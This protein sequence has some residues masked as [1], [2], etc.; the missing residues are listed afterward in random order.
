MVILDEHE[1]RPTVG[2][3]EDRIAE[4]GIDFAV[5]LPIL[6]LKNRAGERDV[7]ER[8]EPFVGQAVVVAFLFFL[9]QPHAAQR[10]SGVFGRNRD[11][12][13]LVDGGPVGV[14]RAV[15]NPDTAGGP[16]HRVERRRHAA[17]GTQALDRLAR[18]SMDV[19]LAIGDHD[20]LIIR[21]LCRR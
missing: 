2:L 16:H 14:A 18:E 4:E 10:V 15:P 8:P 13:G 5:G 20:H 7:A 19:R 11:M 12:I 1:C 6:E 9:G 3:L 17:G 21:H